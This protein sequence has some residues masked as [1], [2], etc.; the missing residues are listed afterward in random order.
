MIPDQ[1]AGVSTAQLTEQSPAP[2][3]DAWPIPQ[4]HF[5]APRP[6]LNRLFLF[7]LVVAAAI[8]RFAALGRQPLWL[9]EAADAAFSARPFWDCI[10][11]E[12]VHPPL[13]RMLLHFVVLRFG[14]SAA[15]ERL[16]PAVFGILAVPLAAILTRRFFPDAEIT[17]AALT[18]TSPFLIFYSQENR[19]YSLFIL[20]ALLS[21][22]A[23]WNF[24]ESGRGLPLYGMLSVLLLYTHHLA[25]FVL[26]AHE[27]V[28][29]LYG[30]RRKHEWVWMRLAVVAAF[31]PW[32]IWVARRYRPESRLFIGPAL[33][34]PSAL[35]RFFVGYGIAASDGVRK[36]AS[37]RLKFF[38][39]GPVVIPAFLIFCWLLWCG[40]RRVRSQALALF[41]AA[42]V[43]IPWTTLVILSPWVQLAHE[44]YVSFQAPFVLMLAAA[45]LCSLHG[46]VRIL[47]TALLAILITFSLTAYYAAPG[48]AFG[49]RF[50]YGKENWAAASDFV[51][52]EHAD[53][54]ILAPGYL[55]LAFDRYPRGGSREIQ[56]ANGSPSAP[57]LRGAKRVA[58][59]LSHDGPAEQRL[60][61]SLDE[62]YP[63]IAEAIFSPQNM[64]RVIVYDTSRPTTIAAPPSSAFQYHQ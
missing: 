33:L 14:D 36:T 61:S 6:A 45:G 17:A 11:A 64:I 63:Q 41:L 34:V 39:E 24:L 21:T 26:L 59:V 40:V 30:R 27:I 2:I 51:R 50:Y 54:V 5:V 1:P 53:T 15:V 28:Y 35:L 43:L 16:L 8:L 29:W 62:A 56:L 20:L 52:R 44:R 32:L 37:W 9:D 48:Q 25:A 19:D 12:T 31:A 46:R 13:Y 23:F 47:A 57:D 58:L 60:R 38:E 49:Y 42:L 3:N 18:A 22:W 4:D 10:F 7:L 55:Y